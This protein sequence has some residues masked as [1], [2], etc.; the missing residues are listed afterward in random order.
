MY[1]T[2]PMDYVLSN[3]TK[4]F[5]L[6]ASLFYTGEYEIK[7]LDS[8]LVKMREYIDRSYK[9]NDDDIEDFGDIIIIVNQYH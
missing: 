8:Y 3:I 9:S 4:E 5:R 1:Q 6:Y 2:K 7:N